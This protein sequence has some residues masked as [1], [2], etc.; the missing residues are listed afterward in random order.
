ME[1]SRKILAVTG[2]T[3]TGKTALAV[4]LARKFRGEIVSADSR[5]VYKHLDIG[6]GKDLAEFG[7][8]DDRVPCHLIDVEEPGGF[9]HLRRFCADAYAAIDDISARGLLL[10]VV[11]GTALYLYALLR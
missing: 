3:A 11:G 7:S 4:A 2:P 8:G 1:K 6:S 9:Y 5:Q 10:I